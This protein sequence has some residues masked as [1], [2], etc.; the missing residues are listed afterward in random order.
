MNNQAPKYLNE[1]TKTRFE[2]NTN[3]SIGSFLVNQVLI[4]ARP[5]DVS[6][7]GIGIQT[8]IELKPGTLVTWR[9]NNQL[10]QLEVMYCESH[11][12]ID[13]LYRIGLFS[14]E[15]ESN[16]VSLAEAAGFKDTLSI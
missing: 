6:A 13:S 14:R 4:L 8:N 11:L 10:L 16:L 1:R 2:C 5:I 7:R 15:A 3:Q 9:L 12:G